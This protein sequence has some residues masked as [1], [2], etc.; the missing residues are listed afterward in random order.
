[1]KNK[2]I[3]VGV[4][5]DEVLRAKWLQFDRFYAQE[6]G[7]ENIP[8]EPY[9]FDFFNDYA[10]DAVNEKVKEL[11]DDDEILNSITPL[12]YQP[13]ENGNVAADLV[14]FDTKEEK[15]SALDVFNRFMYIDFCFE[16][17]G[18]A[19]QMYKGLDY[20]FNE[21]HR[22][23]ND[24]IE[25]VIISNENKQSIPPTLFFLSKMQCRADE[26]KLNCIG[27]EKLN[28]VDILITSDPE[29]L[30]NK[31]PKGKKVI[32]IERP[33]NVGC[34]NCEISTIQLYELVGNK[35]FEKL[36]KFK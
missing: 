9:S 33:Y 18:T 12:D 25:L 31:A 17:F 8:E 28:N 16:I 35:E 2:K 27:E 22:K 13:D 36:I 15:L 30:I 6:F 20:H 14:L 3:R 1:M 34:D 4:D 10:W 19:P 21:F 23:Y 11:I 7:E 5:I 26:Y 29:L 24:H 32:K